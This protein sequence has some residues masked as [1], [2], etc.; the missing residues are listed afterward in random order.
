MKTYGEVRHGRGVFAIKCEP[1]VSMRLKRMWAG[2]RQ[3]QTGEL[4]WDDTPEHAFEID[5]ML[6]RWPMDM[7]PDVATH[8][9]T[10]AREYR[11]MREQVDMVLAGYQPPLG[12]SE[13]IRPPRGYQEQACRLVWTSNGLLLGDDLGLG[14]SM[15]GLLVLRDPDA[16]PALVVTLTHLPGQWVEELHK[17]L[18]WLTAHAATKGSYYDV[19][20]DTD[21]LV[22]NYHKLVGWADHLAGR[23]RTVIFDECQELR[24][25]AGT[26]MAPICKYQAAQRVAVEARFRMGLS[27][28]PVYNYGGEIWHIL[29]VLSP[30]SLGDL[31]EFSHAWCT[32]WGDKMRAKDPKALGTYLRDQ[33]L[34]LR[35]TRSEVGRELP[36][37]QRIVHT[38]DVNDDDVDRLAVGAD[39]LATKILA[40]STP[41]KE[42]FTLSGEFSWKLRHAT[43]MA[44]A[45]QVATFTE[46]LLDSEPV[47]LFGWHIDVYD[48]WRDRLKAWNPQFFT[49]DETPKQKDASR[50]AFVDGESRLLIMSLRAGAGLDG[51]QEVCSVAVFGE[52]D[53]SPG[54]HDQCIGRLNRDGQ[55]T[56][57]M[58]YF[59]A[60][61]SGSDPVVIDTL[62]AK[63][64]QAD[65][66]R[67]PNAE[68]ITN[69]V[70]PDRIR[71]LA[72][73]YLD[74][75]NHD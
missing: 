55:T 47:I 33:G 58:A 50:Q 68:A 46:L 38:V 10:R 45:Q 11:D 19:P 5:W 23:C 3:L 65:P 1:H 24:R 26:P 64:M 51:L 7:T 22:M 66:I 37:V 14:K 63:R 16:L 17:T 20:P 6:A 54:V 32:G 62:T 71:T 18:P 59:L 52:L 4:H 70:D 13:A 48:I 73:N 21:V 15:S 39:D 28:T 72:A 61:T 9:E 43:G 12:F 67:D 2:L 60:A 49:G 40:A 57:V 25:G 34:M 36:D 53:W 35:R 75:K 56:P 27:A 30:G 41:N 8:L 69:Q 44:K 29:N 31:A 74:R 42:R